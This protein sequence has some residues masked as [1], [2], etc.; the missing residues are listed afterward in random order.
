[1]RSHLNAMI[2]G[3]C[4]VLAGF[5]LGRTMPSPEP[6]AEAQTVVP[7]NLSPFRSGNPAIITSSA[8]GRTLHIWSRA[9]SSDDEIFDNRRPVYV[10][11]VESR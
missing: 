4:L 7:A 9:N 8:D 10:G 5:G 2:I 3:G 1:M 11:S 6:T